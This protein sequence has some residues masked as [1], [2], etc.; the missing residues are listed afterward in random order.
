MFPVGNYMHRRLITATPTK[1]VA[2]R[3][4]AGVTNPIEIGK[5]RRRLD[6]S[7][8]L[9]TASIPVGR[10]WRRTG[11]MRWL[12]RPDVS[13]APNVTPLFVIERLGR[14]TARSRV[15]PM[16]DR[17]R[18]RL[19]M[20]GSIAR[21]WA[22]PRS[23]DL[24]QVSAQRSSCLQRKTTSTPPSSRVGSKA[25]RREPTATRSHRVCRYVPGARADP[26]WS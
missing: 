12:P 11:P 6:A 16:H 15:L 8:C 26:G 13:P 5:R 17:P 24:P 18:R 20:P 3:R 19:P 21:A 10:C 7:E 23:A 4:L 14:L 2:E 22:V 25:C 9:A 1:I